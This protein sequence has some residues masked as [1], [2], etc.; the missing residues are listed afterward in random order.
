M[1]FKFIRGITHRN[2]EPSSKKFWYNV[3][4]LAATAIILYLAYTLPTERGMEDWV[5]VWLFAIYLVTVG[6]FEVILQMMRMMLEWK[7][8]TQKGAA[9]VQAKADAE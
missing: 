6:G 1:E 9:D 4:G 5:F 8:G 3:A 7:N 2:G